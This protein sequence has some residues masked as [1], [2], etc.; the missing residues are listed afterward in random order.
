MPYT[1]RKAHHTKVDDLLDYIMNEEKTD[2][3]LLITGH[4]CNP[5]LAKKEFLQTAA[6]RQSKRNYDN[7]RVGYHLIQSFSP[8]DKI[9]PNQAHEI[10]TRLCKELYP[11]YQAVITTHI[12]RGHIHNHIGLNSVSL[13]GKKLNDKNNT[14]EGLYAIRNKSDEISAEYGCYIIPEVNFK[15]DNSKKAEMY[16]SYKHQTWRKT[17]LEDM[18]KLKLESNSMSEFI[19]KLFDMGYDVKYGKYISVKPQ[20]KERFVRLKTLSEEFSEDNL[21]LFFNGKQP[22]YYYHFKKYSENDYNSKYLEYYRE[23]QIALE[24]TASVAIKGGKLPQFQ[25]TRRKTEIQA[26]QVQGVLDLLKR[27]NINSYDDLEN[28]IRFCRNKIHNANIKIRKFER[29]N[30]DIV[31]MIDKAQTFLSMKKEYDYAM[32]YKSIDEDYPLPEELK[33]FDAL[34]DEL[35]ISTEAEAKELIKSAGEIRKE[36]N[37]QKSAIYEMQQEL[38]EYD[39]L[40]E[41]QLLKSDMFIHNIKVGNNRIDYQNCTEDEWCIHIPYSDYYVMISKTLATYNHKYGYNTLFLIDDKSYQLYVKDENGALQT[42]QALSGNQLDRFVAEMKQM[43]IE[44]HKDKKE[45]Y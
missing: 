30:K 24:L 15:Y 13:E 12:D 45:E 5:D 34:K 4:N 18:K 43:N 23:L 36:L 39:I 2:G 21:R 40:K 17:I 14:D 31:E 35:G 32:Y 28:K 37:Q 8:D 3:G 25:K 9:T 38:F 44:Q 27:E 29:E 11:N 10:A 20:G 1:K 7:E 22:D 26:E 33:I 42:A 19:V 16:Y 41:E 6:K